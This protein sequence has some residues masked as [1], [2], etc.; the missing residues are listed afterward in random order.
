MKGTLLRKRSTFRLYLVF[1][2]M[3]FPKNS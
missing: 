3:D 2:W 1:N